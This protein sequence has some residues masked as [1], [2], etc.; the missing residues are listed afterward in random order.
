[1]VYFIRR[2]SDGKYS[3]GG[4]YNIGFY[5]E[6][7]RFYTFKGIRSSVKAHLKRLDY[8][9]KRITENPYGN[10]TNMPLRRNSYEDINNFEVLDFDYQSLSVKRVF[11][12]SEI[13]A[14]LKDDINES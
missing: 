7:V 14:G 5:D 11:T 9:N 4:K 6:P 8:E 2:I 13:L 12:L 10:Y 1:M 3:G